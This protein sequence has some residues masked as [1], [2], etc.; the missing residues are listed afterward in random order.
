MGRLVYFFDKLPPLTHCFYIRLVVDLNNLAMNRKQN[1]RKKALFPGLCLGTDKFGRIY[2]VPRHNAKIDSYEESSSESD[3]AEHQENLCIDIL[4]E[5]GKI[6]SESDG[7]SGRQE[8]KGILE[9]A[10]STRFEDIS[11]T[12]CPE[13]L[14]ELSSKSP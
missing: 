10:E 8:H 14:A 7:I 4:D 1:L 5:A 12:E 2:S 6:T 13:P 3:C 9:S 11:C